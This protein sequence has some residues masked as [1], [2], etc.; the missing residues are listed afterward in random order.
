MLA[1]KKLSLFCGAAFLVLQLGGCAS[2]IF[3]DIDEEEDDV[4]VGEGGRLVRESNSLKA[5]EENASYEGE[6]DGENDADEAQSE[7]E[8]QPAGDEESDKDVS[9]LLSESDEAEK[10]AAAE[11]IPVMSE[12]LKSDKPAQPAV[13]T[14]EN[15][16][17]ASAGPSISYRLD[18][19]L[20]ANGSAAVDSS[21]NETIKRAVKA[22][23]ANDAK[24]IVYGYAS[25]RTR[26]TDP[27]SH[28][29]ANFK[30][31]LERAQNVA[32]ALRRAGMPADRISIEALSD[33][34]PLYQEVMPE[35]ERL[36]RRAEIYISY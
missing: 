26:N 14:I 18:T 21:Y 17:E 5:D 33:S 7:E 22:A 28:K 11:T 29:M 10:A 13:Q 3:P 32:A 8:A 31:S 4:V 25:S 24:I 12:D 20:F 27:V 6:D 36:N 34:A 2:A 16:T 19:I 9:D 23:K 15:L 1:L 35:G 30:V